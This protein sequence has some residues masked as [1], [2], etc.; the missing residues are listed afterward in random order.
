MKK[1]T[2]GDVMV[3][4]RNAALAISRIARERGIDIRI[5]CRDEGS[6]MVRAGDYEYMRLGAEER[7]RCHFMPHDK[8][9]E[10][11]YD[12]R[13][14]EVSFGEGESRCQSLHS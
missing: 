1:M 6:V 3:Y 14:Q 2:D 13:P 12:I 11:K 8:N 10:W 4:L 5:S 7:E 9:R